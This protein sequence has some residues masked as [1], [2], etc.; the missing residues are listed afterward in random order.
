MADAILEPE[1]FAEAGNPW[2]K[3]FTLRTGELTVWAGANSAGKSQLVLQLMLS[4]LREG[5]RVC[6]MS[7]EIAPP[8]TLLR[9]IR[10][11]VGREPDPD[12]AVRFFN[13]CGKSLWI[14]RNQDTV[15]SEYMLD[16][17]YYAATELQC[18]HIVVDNLMMVVDGANS[19]AVMSN[20][21]QVAQELKAISAQTGAHIHLIAHLRK[22]TGQQ[23][24]APNRYDIAGTGKI[25]NL[26]DNVALVIRNGSKEQSAKGRGAL[27]PDLDRQP[28]T[29]IRVD[30]QRETGVIS[31]T[32]LW[33]EPVSGQFC[34]SR[35]R[36]LVQFIPQEEQPH[37]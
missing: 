4:M 27:T 11:A 2:V 5:K 25:S 14:Y 10:I 35:E 36:R 37:A 3:S 31:N 22:P 7:F 24:D 9:M 16:A 18:S 13:W 15:S 29:V 21:S 33:F 12:D 23:A 20:Q 6:V 26:A 1:S 30:K 32:P 17:A 8:K 28:D 19:D 34:R